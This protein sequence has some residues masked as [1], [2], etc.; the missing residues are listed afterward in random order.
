[1]GL[2]KKTDLSGPEK[3]IVLAVTLAILSVAAA[4]Y[5]IQY[6][7]MN[8]AMLDD[9]RTRADVV[10]RYAVSRILNEAFTSIN[11]PDD[12]SSGIYRL[13]QS[14]LNDIREIANVRYLYTA[15]LNA[16]GRAV[17][18]VDGLPSS[19]PDFRHPGDRIEDDI[20]PVLRTC[21]NGEPVTSP[22][23]MDTEW[24]AIF[25]TCM[26]IRGGEE[27]PLGA[28][29]MEFNADAIRGS[30]LESM[31]YSGVLTLIVA[32]IC[33]LAMLVSLRRLA[34]PFYRKL[35]YTDMLTGIGNRTAFELRLHELEKKREKH[36]ILALYDLNLLK[37]LNDSL[38]HAAG[39]AYL[40][41]MAGLLKHAEP[42]RRGQSFRIGGDEFVTL[43]L[44]EDEETLRQELEM[45]RTG[46]TRVEAGG[47][48]VAFACGLAAYDPALDRESLHNTL[49]RADAL[50]YENK[51]AS[52]GMRAGDASI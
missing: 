46:S 14:M 5:T 31:L 25:L 4:L 2:F 44:N 33:L 38:G 15:R 41:R 21:L 45:F 19:S 34:T 9:I 27:K 8:R 1:M 24:G 20:L 11:G 3:R 43:F 13:T 26:P 7:V 6:M 42:P 48:P 36:V 50:M 39:D 12:T 49:R 23:V 22:G 18:L 52:R 16:D 17:Y 28:V 40:R 29:V 10:N 35:A 37:R 32:G 47:Q 30:M 51:K